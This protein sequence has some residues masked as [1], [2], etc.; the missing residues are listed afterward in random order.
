MAGLEPKRALGGPIPGFPGTALRLQVGFEPGIKPAS[1]W[2]AQGQT[3]VLLAACI[4]SAC[5]D[6]AIARSALLGLCSCL[7]MED[8]PPAQQRSGSCMAQITAGN[9]PDLAV[10]AMQ[11]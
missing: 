1:V 9:R 6:P 3:E 10:Y 5:Q 2:E 7:A 8:S 4:S 11:M